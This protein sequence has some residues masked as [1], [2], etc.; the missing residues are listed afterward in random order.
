MSYI[1]NPN[2]SSLSSQ[3]LSYFA[4][5]GVAS[6]TSY[7]FSQVNVPTTLFTNGFPQ[8]DGTVLK[9][10]SNK[11]V[12]EWF[13]LHFNSTL[14]LG[15]DDQPGNYELAILSDDGA[16]L[17]LD[18]GSGLKTVIA[19]AN[20]HAT[21][22]VCAPSTIAMTSTS[23]IPLDLFY[24]Q[25]PR[26]H[27]ALVMMWR[28]IPQGGSLSEM[29]CN[30]GGNEYFWDPNVVPSTPKSP[31]QGLLARGWKVLTPDNFEL[32]QTSAD[33]PCADKK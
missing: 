7:V 3:P 6:S 19:D 31:Y 26:Y 17:K 21:E 23:K 24:V 20:Q 4:S 10:G 15:P 25:G 2:A 33:N 1:L 14:K 9:D 27:I 29:E 18:T 12:I 13:S 5:H 30:N 28:H 16:I 22:M 32:P 11:E 8:G